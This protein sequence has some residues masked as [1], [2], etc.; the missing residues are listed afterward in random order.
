KQAP[1]APFN[2]ELQALALRTGKTYLHQLPQLPRQPIEVFL[3]FEGI[4][5]RDFYYLIGC[6]V[7]DGET[8]VQHSFWANTQR[9]EEAI[10]KQFLQT[11]TAYPDAPLFPFG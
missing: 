8:R 1:P 10:W 3:D 5:D 2:P 9:E 6:L 11:M 7:V 4:S